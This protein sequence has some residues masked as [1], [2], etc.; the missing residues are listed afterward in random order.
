M[1]AVRARWR[2]LSRHIANVRDLLV[3]LASELGAWARAR[4]S[5]FAT[6]A[7]LA[8]AAGLVVIDLAGGFSTWWVNH[9]LVTA[10]V[11]GSLSGFITGLI[12]DRRSR[13][14]DRR[15]WRFIRDQVVSNLSRAAYDILA[16]IE[17]ELQIAGFEA[18]GS[19][20]PTESG[21]GLIRQRVETFTTQ[22]DRWS[23]LLMVVD[24]NEF[25]K[26][27]T[28]FAERTRRIAREAATVSR[29]LLQDDWEYFVGQ[30]ADASFS[31]ARDSLSDVSD[32]VQR[33]RH[34]R[35]WYKQRREARRFVGLVEAQNR[36]PADDANG[37]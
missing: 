16:A 12:L 10:L 3:M 26:R 29:R 18:D 11:I 5:G 36:A 6:G 4:R 30:L 24:E 22:L 2:A 14:R 25:L 32:E 23:D 35:N 7:V 8:L 27:S 20:A 19:A 31:K 9:A 37:Q 34:G 15:R 17:P 28:E 21:P 13:V 33:A 1:S